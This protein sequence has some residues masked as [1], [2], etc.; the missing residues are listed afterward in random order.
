MLLIDRISAIRLKES[1]VRLFPWPRFLKIVRELI[2]LAVVELS[3][4]SLV[5]HKGWTEVV[6]FRLALSCRLSGIFVR[7]YWEVPQ[8]L[9]L[10]NRLYLWENI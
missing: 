2:S 3:R 4:C 1:S 9:A 6:S 10:K 8:L 5:W 7:C